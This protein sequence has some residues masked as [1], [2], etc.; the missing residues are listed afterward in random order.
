MEIKKVTGLTKQQKAYHDCYKLWKDC[1][2]DSKQ[3]MDYY[4]SEKLIDN[5]VYM[6]EEDGHVVSMLHLNPYE[7]MVEGE[8]LTANYIVGVATE[9]AY[10]KRGYM[11]RLLKAAFHDMYED[12]QLFTYLMPA[13]YAIYAPYDFRYIYEQRRLSLKQPEGTMLQAAQ[14][15]ARVE[16][17]S[18][19]ELEE[20]KKEAA[21]HMANIML[22]ERFDV[23]PYRSMH[24]YERMSKEMK[25]ADGDV[26]VVQKE[27]RVVGIISYM[28]EQG[29]HG[30]EVAI[31]ES[32]LDIEDTSAIFEQ[33][34]EVLAEGTNFHFYESEYVN[35]YAMESVFQLV[36]E[37]SKPIIMA[38][39]IDVKKLLGTIRGEETTRRIRIQDRWMEQNNGT[40]ELKYDQHSCTVVEV[41][42][43]AEDEENVMDIP[44][45]VE[46]VFSMKKVYINDIV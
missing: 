8:I 18:W 27:N 12:G 39:P 40:Y 6:L 28:T 16:L 4:F 21:I 37:Q 31:V 43:T 46:W 32:L 24:Y 29:E 23:Y 41:E 10:R 1:F 15:K 19:D 45:L 35:K 2:G 44:A 33:V 9:E 11:G 13:A 20:I 34:K 30:Q 36:D 3:Y 5:T 42:E 25:A 38:R 7:M 14:V 22:S 26:L 17:C